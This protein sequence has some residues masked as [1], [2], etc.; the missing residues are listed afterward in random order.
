MQT[1]SNKQ[2]RE[3][4]GNH[5]YLVNQRLAHET[6]RLAVLAEELDHPSTRLFTVERMLNRGGTLVRIPVEAMNGAEAARI[7][8]EVKYALD[9]D[10]RGKEP[11]SWA[12]N[13]PDVQ[14]MVK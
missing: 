9:W 14:R 6:T 2:V 4:H 5:S 1:H 12:R 8:N 10:G 7:A 13:W 11:E 3:N